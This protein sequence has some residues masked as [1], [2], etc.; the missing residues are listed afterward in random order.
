V[1]KIRARTGLFDGRKGVFRNSSLLV[2]CLFL[3]GFSLRTH[4]PSHVQIRVPSG[5]NIQGHLLSAQTRTPYSSPR[6]GLSPFPNP[7]KHGIRWIYRTTELT[8]SRT[9]TD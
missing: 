9:R 8:T 3:S 6:T 4:H 2:V 7:F 5:S 1:P